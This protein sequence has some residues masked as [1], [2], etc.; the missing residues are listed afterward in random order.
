MESHDNVDEM[1]LRCEV[2]IGQEALA[3]EIAATLQSV[4]KVRGRVT[5]ARPGELPNDGKVIADLRSYNSA[6]ANSPGAVTVDAVWVG[7]QNELAAAE[8]VVHV[9]QDLAERE[10]GLVFIELALENMR[11]EFS[12]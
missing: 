5:F 4:S 8:H 9:R 11:D 12:N 7:L 1:T 6:M 2:A 3:A 10:A